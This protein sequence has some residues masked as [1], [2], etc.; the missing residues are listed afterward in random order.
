MLCV[1][2]LP[3]LECYSILEDLAKIFFPMKRIKPFKFQ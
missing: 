1:N 2:Y 3:K